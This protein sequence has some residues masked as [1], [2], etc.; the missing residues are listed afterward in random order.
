MLKML[1]VDVIIK[2]G[3]Y[4]RE[5]GTIRSDVEQGKVTKKTESEKK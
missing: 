2:E 3:N 4:V 1:N 5:K